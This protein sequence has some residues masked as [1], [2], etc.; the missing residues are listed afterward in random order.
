MVLL[1]VVPH[2]SPSIARIGRNEIPQERDQTSTLRATYLFL[3]YTTVAE[4]L[5]VCHV[6]TGRFI[7]RSFGYSAASLA[8]SHA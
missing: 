4:T 8:A 1:L 3:A 6:V 2:N 7:T 5:G